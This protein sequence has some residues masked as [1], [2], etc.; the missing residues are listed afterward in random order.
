MRL[1]FRGQL[2]RILNPEARPGLLAAGSRPK[3]LLPLLQTL[4]L[5]QI[6]WI[7]SALPVISEKGRIIGTAKGSERSF[8]RHSF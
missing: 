4:G 1:S 5:M 2:S 3:L 7:D 8:M 6:H